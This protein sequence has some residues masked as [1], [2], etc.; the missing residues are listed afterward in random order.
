MLLKIY[1][2]KRFVVWFKN[3]KRKKR[4]IKTK[5]SLKNKTGMG[6]GIIKPNA[7]WRL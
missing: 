2:I 5:K 3:N 4:K 6:T 1:A 7:S